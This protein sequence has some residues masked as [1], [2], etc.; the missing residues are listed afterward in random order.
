MEDNT[1]S[2]GKLS[3]VY[4]KL[5]LTRQVYVELLQFQE[6]Y[7]KNI[8]TNSKLIHNLIK[9]VEKRL[10]ERK[11]TTNDEETVTKME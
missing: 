3:K 2:D 7:A 4:V 10:E 1:N 11:N 5:N 8:R 9:F 6:K